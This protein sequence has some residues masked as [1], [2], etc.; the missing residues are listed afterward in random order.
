MEEGVYLDSLDDFERVMTYDAD[1][2]TYYSGIHFSTRDCFYTGTYAHYGYDKNTTVPLPPI[3]LQRGTVAIVVGP[4][5]TAATLAKGTFIGLSVEF[6]KGTGHVANSSKSC[7]DT[8]G[9]NDDRCEAEFSQLSM[10]GTAALFGLDADDVYAVAFGRA[11][12]PPFASSPACRTFDEQFISAGANASITGRVYLNPTT[13]VG[14]AKEEMMPA[15]VM[16][17]DPAQ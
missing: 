10:N 2:A 7:A 17:F 4:L 12:P 14:P 6:A 9:R 3:N 15:F 5:S 13:T 8:Y 1:D 11:C 16:V